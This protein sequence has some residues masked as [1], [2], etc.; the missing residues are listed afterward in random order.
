MGLVSFGE[1]AAN[2]PLLFGAGKMTFAGFTVLCSSVLED[3][4][5]SSTMEDDVKRVYKNT[6]MVKYAYQITLQVFEL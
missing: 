4:I 5:W 1:D 2:I 6:C 3:W